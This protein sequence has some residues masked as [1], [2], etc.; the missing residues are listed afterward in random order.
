M[1]RYRL[2]YE[3]KKRGMNVDVL[4]EKIGINRA[5]FYRKMKGTSEFTQGEIQ[6]IVDVLELES[7][8]GIFFPEKVSETTQTEVNA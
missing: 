2:E 3:M 8:M 5:T 1:D 4:A 6:K 7:P